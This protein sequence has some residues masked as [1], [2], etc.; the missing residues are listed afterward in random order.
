MFASPTAWMK[1][2]NQGVCRPVTHYA[3][4]GLIPTTKG[5]ELREAMFKGKGNGK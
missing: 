5:W 1:H 2:F 4:M 3:M